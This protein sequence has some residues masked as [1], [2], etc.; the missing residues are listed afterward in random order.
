MLVNE[1]NDETQTHTHTGT[2]SGCT[3]EDRSP[4]TDGPERVGVY[5][6]K[7]FPDPKVQTE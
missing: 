6:S 3:T 7:S 4:S 5:A 1:L 2:H